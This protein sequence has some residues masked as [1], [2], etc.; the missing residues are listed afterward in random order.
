M[1]L[2]NK[3]MQHCDICLFTCCLVAVPM[4]CNTMPCNSMPCNTMQNAMQFNTVQ[5][6]PIHCR[7]SSSPT[8]EARAA[9]LHS[10]VVPPLFRAQSLGVTLWCW[11]HVD[12]TVWP[13][14][15]VGQAC[16]VAVEAKDWGFR[17]SV[18]SLHST[19]ARRYWWVLP[20]VSAWV[21][22]LGCECCWK[23]ECKCKCKCKHKCKHK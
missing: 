14:G 17:V 9:V 18:V 19:F 12:L 7:N 3:R 16:A 15:C 23:C 5:C 13:I 1:H 21:P 4:R 2:V 8:P 11:L 10:S 6:T 20:C 22:C